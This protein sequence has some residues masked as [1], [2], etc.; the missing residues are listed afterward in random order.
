MELTMPLMQL[1]MNG[2]YCG[3]VGS[4]FERYRQFG[5]GGVRPWV[6]LNSYGLPSGRKYITVPLRRPDGSFIRNNKGEVE[7]Y[8]LLTNAPASLRQEDWLRIDETISELPKKELRF[9]SD[10]Y[11]ANPYNLANGYGTIALQRAVGDWTATATISMDPIRRGEFSKPSLDTQ[12]FPIPVIH[13]DNDFTSRDIAVSQNGNFPLD[14]RGVRAAAQAVMLSVEQ[15]CL[16]T[17]ASYSYGGN[18]IYGALNHPLR[19]TKV[20]STPTGANNA[21]II[22]EI[23]QMV[24]TLRDNLFKGP[25]VAYY[26]SNYNQWMELDYSTAYPGISL[27]DR[28]AKVSGITEWRQHDYLTGYQILIVQMDADTVEGING[29]PMTTVQWDEHGGFQQSFKVL[30]I[31]L[32]YFHS[33]FDGKLGINHGTAP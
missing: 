26:S 13:S 22:L 31:Y 32:P 21:T 19:F 16:G 9:W 1:D 23:V 4:A 10:I 3:G 12:V 5:L 29:M 27:R 15:L 2:L 11:G 33:R 28:L 6:H 8:N 7:T 25:Y 24:Q 20:L 14:V 17:A 18:T 30:C